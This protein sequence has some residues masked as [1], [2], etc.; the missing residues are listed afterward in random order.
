MGTNLL[1]VVWA[2]GVSAALGLGGVGCAG[3]S[4]ERNFAERFAGSIEAAHGARA[5]RSKQ[6]VRAG[7]TVDFGGQRVLDGTIR[8]DTSLER[9]RM[10]LADGSVMTFDGKEAWVSP[11]DSAVEGARFHLLTWPYFVAVPMKLHDPGSHLTDAGMLPLRGGEM[12]AGRLTFDPGIG[13][14]PDDWYLVYRD[15]ATER[16]AAMAYIVTF[17]TDVEQAE[18]EPHAITYSGWETID[19]VTLS[20][21]WEFWNWDHQRGVHGEPIG[22]VELSGL[23]FVGYDA[24][25]FLAPSGARH[26]PLPGVADP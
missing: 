21:V 17:G 14:S 16:L 4:P 25:D 3:V 26:E 12:R 18:K 7:I 19:G 22:R 2:I 23:R 20:T 13:D 8:F 6:A 11:A 1:R 5:W 15:P 9:V 24:S 10:E